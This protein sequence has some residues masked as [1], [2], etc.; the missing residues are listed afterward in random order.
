MAELDGLIETNREESDALRDSYMAAQ[1]GED[2]F[3]VQYKASRIS[4]HSR[5][6]KREILQYMKL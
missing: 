4:A 1:L 6:A 2:E 3:I 5:M